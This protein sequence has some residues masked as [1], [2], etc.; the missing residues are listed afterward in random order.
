MDHLPEVQLIAARPTAEAAEDVA[1]QMYGEAERIARSARVVKRAGTTKTVPTPPSRPE[2]E[3][4][5]HV[6][7]RDVRTQGPIVDSWHYVLPS[8][9]VVESAPFLR[10]RRRARRAR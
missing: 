7:H 6:L 3:Q 8:E 2:A 4:A 9:G 10:S 1:A 5:Q